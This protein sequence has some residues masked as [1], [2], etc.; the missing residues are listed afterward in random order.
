MMRLLAV[1]VALITTVTPPLIAQTQQCAETTIPKTLPPAHEMVDS[2]N[3]IAELGAFHRLSGH[4]L[5]SVVFTDAD[6]VPSV[7]ALEGADA[8]AALVLLRSVWPQK[9]TGTWAL[10][11]RVVADSATG[12][13]SLALE[14][15]IYCPP[16]PVRTLGPV[17]E[18]RVVTRAGAYVPAPGEARL[19]VEVEVSIDEAGN[20][21][22]ARVTQSSDMAELDNDV[23]Q[24]WLTRKFKPA[25]IDGRPIR[26]LYRT[27]KHSPKL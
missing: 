5:F 3:A 6:S 9:P 13:A 14:R 4:M 26:A 20:V 21:T 1:S 17:R 23:V 2:A 22:R 11:V 25:L 18:Q 12:T 24:D 7:S 8:Q 27:D 15:S 10:R 16:I 19:P